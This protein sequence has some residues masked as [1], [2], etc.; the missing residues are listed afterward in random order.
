MD[1]QNDEMISVPEASNKLSLLCKL[2]RMI[3]R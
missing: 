1:Q 3:E 2:K